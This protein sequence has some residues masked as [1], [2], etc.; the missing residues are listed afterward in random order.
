MHKYTC[1]IT[2]RT[3]STHQLVPDTRTR[4]TLR[5]LLCAFG[6][7]PGKLGDAVRFIMRALMSTY[8]AG[9]PSVLYDYSAVL[10]LYSCYNT[11]FLRASQVEKPPTQKP[12][13]FD[14]AP[15]DTLSH[16]RTCAR[17]KL[18]YFMLAYKNI[19]STSFPRQFTC[20]AAASRI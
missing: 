17:R 12:A 19:Y 9:P 1:T 10:V 20:T 11:C 7:S 8:C 3:A 6:A 14:T 18:Y 4:S 16:G 5:R 13:R 2:K 15:H